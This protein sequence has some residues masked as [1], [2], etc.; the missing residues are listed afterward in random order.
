MGQVYGAHTMREI[1]VGEYNCN[2]EYSD[3]SEVTCVDD[4][5]VVKKC[6][7][8][9][10]SQMEM[11][12]YVSQMQVVTIFTDD[13][14]IR[15]FNKREYTQKIIKETEYCEE[16]ECE[17]FSDF[18]GIADFKTSFILYSNRGNGSRYSLNQ[19][20]LDFTIF[21]ESL[22]SLLTKRAFLKAYRR[23]MGY[24]DIF[25]YPENYDE[26]SYSILYKDE[27]EWMY[28]SI[29]NKIEHSVKC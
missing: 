6:N 3:L 29:M 17:P 10:I 27:V 26:K 1:A 8:Q 12:I 18:T 20:K 14:V 11:R 4:S 28:T 22:S 13:L 7:E 16:K 19:I 23:S 25:T 2:D 21:Y 5:T 9:R 15:R 24:D